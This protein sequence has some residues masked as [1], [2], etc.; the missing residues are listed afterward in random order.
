MRLMA[1]I[2]VLVLSAGL[3]G[4]LLALQSNVFAQ[5]NN[6]PRRNPSQQS[7]VFAQGFGFPRS[8]S[9]SNFGLPT[10]RYGRGGADAP[11]D[12]GAK[13]E[14]AFGRLVYSNLGDFGPPVQHRRLRAWSEDWPYADWHFAE[15][16][17]RLTRID[18]RHDDETVDLT[19]DQLFNWPWI[20]ANQVGNWS[21]PDDQAKRLREYL[22]K[23]GF[24]LVDNFHGGQAWQNFMA[25]IRKVFPDRPV[26]ELPVSDEI[27]HTLYDISERMQVPGVEYEQT[28]KT[29]VTYVPDGVEP[30]WRAI[31]D[32]Q[33]RI[34]VAICHNM[35]LGDSWERA[36]D[37]LYP[38]RFTSFAYRV[39][40]DY[41]IYSL[42]H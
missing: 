26:E 17:Q 29:Y 10:A 9:Q 14:W 4:G 12:S 3:G 27:Y 11:N 5:R 1:R 34:M 28:G 36:D 2:L 38:E 24:L 31:R 39:G 18:A 25:G 8:R 16:V 23:G 19:S 35:H 20:Y 40:M 32:D 30:H 37:P 6:F 41:L 42:T 22:L 7:G 33:G 15:G 21:L 13:T